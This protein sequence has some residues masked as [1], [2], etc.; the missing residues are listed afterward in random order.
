MHIIG[1]KSETYAEDLLYTPKA[2]SLNVLKGPSWL[3]TQFCVHAACCS[4]C[5]GADVHE[6]L[7]KTKNKKETLWAC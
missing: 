1:Y 5:D 6:L 2:T 7:E 3:G 4:G